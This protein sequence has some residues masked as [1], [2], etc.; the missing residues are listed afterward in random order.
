METPIINATGAEVLLSVRTLEG[1]S[2]I[3]IGRYEVTLSAEEEEWLIEL[4]LCERDSL[5][6][7]IAHGVQEQIKSTISWERVRDEPDPD[8]VWGEE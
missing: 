2:D 1:M 6:G 7:E 5:L 3:P 4:S 8:R